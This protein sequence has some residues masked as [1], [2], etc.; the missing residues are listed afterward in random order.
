MYIVLCYDNIIVKYDVQI[1]YNAQ[2]RML[3]FCI[4]FDTQNVHKMEI[5]KEKEL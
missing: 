1:N 5:N 4:I 2:K 3:K